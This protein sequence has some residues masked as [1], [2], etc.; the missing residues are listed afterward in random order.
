MNTTG[1]MKKCHRTIYKDLSDLKQERYFVLYC[2]I[3]WGNKK[4]STAS[5]EDWRWNLLFC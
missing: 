3:S 2:N 5:L 4:Y 1:T